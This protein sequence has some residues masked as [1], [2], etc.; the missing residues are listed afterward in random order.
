M[1]NAERMKA[2]YWERRHGRRCV[3]CDAG[4]QE[5]DTPDALYCVECIEARVDEQA[6]YDAKPSTKKK[7]A[8]QA[9]SRYAKAPATHAKKKR[10]E[11][12]GRK[13]EGKCYHCTEDALEDSNF[14][15]RHRDE[16]RASSRERARVRT[17]YYDRHPN[18]RP[19]VIEERQPYRVA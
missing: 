19:S 5:T 3:R 16:N 8:D 18:E 15:Q 17:G 2:R 7:K 4:L 12:N 14:C 10:D 13:A 6:R 1:T 9:R 11:R